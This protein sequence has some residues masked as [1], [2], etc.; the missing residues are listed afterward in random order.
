M[1]AELLYQGLDIFCGAKPVGHVVSEEV[2]VPTDHLMGGGETKDTQRDQ[3]LF[4]LKSYK[5]IK[6]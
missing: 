3:K 4:L 1:S 6:S 5:N 2:S